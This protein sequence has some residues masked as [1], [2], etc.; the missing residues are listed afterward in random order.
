[1]EEIYRSQFRLPQGLY[2]LLKAAADE[3]H[4]SVNAELV[5]R[6]EMS[7]SKRE[8]TNLSLGLPI[9]EEDP[10]Q[11]AAQRPAD[12]LVEVEDRLMTSLIK[13]INEYRP[14]E[15]LIIAPDNAKPQPNTGPK[16]R[17]RFPKK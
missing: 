12:H 15:R 3:N 7:F 8:R 5:S 17:K 13:L 6:L 4:R 14:N 16:P 10:G 9:G 11:D 1:M 2:E